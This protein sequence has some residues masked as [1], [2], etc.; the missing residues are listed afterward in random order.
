MDIPEAPAKPP[1]GKPPEKS[2]VPPAYLELVEMMELF[3][4]ECEH[5]EARADD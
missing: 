3:L 2:Q 5:Y 1:K 4:I